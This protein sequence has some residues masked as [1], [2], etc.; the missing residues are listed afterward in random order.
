[1]TDTKSELVQVLASSK[2]CDGNHA[3]T[4]CGS[5]Q[6]W[7]RLDRGVV[8]E[9]AIEREIVES[10]QV[11]IEADRAAD[12][13]AH[14]AVKVT[15][16]MNEAI[17]ASKASSDVLAFERVTGAVR[18]HDEAQRRL[19]MK[20]AA[21]QRADGRWRVAASRLAA[22][23]GHGQGASNRN[24]ILA[25]MDGDKDAKD[26]AA[27][28]NLKPLEPIPIGARPRKPDK[29]R[30]DRGDWTRASG[31]VVCT[32]GFPYADHDSVRGFEWLTRLCDGRL[33][34]L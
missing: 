11:W 19:A 29:A 10:S 9:A 23:R 31:L 8:Y 14:E 17:D 15:A 7:R 13:A 21:E 6:C 26:A 27:P 20:I 30:V 33:V 2:S 34:K 22:A 3:P 4:L 25:G 16:A 24:Q 5:D 12:A 18:M 28:I 1:M 32:C